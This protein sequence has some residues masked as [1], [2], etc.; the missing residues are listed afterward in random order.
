MNATTYATNKDF[1]KNIDI[2]KKVKYGSKER[3]IVLPPEDFAYGV[4]N[5]PPTP[6]KDVINNAYGN[7]AESVIR[8]EYATFMKEKQKMFHLTPRTT[9]HFNKLYELSRTRMNYDNQP[10][11]E[12]YKMRMFKDV[13][14]KVAEGIKQFK[15]YHPYKKNNLDSMI[16]KVQGEL[17]DAGA[18]YQAP[19]QKVH[20]S[21]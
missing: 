3:H 11:P 15:T 18:N 4:P 1:R 8:K 19:P 20:I 5:R 14:S 2:R 6:I 10:E 9:N 21:N 12:L 16:E 7:R 13:G 17:N